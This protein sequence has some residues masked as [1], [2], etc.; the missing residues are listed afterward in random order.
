MWKRVGEDQGT[1]YME[2]LM[3]HI[4]QKEGKTY[5]SALKWRLPSL[6]RCPGHYP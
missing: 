1:G 4:M 6:F 3:A 5:T 2:D